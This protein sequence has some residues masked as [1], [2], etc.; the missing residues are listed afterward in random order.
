MRAI[1]KRLREKIK[2]LE[3]ENQAIKDDRQKFRE[4]MVQDLRKAIEHVRCN[5]YSSGNYIVEQVAKRMAS[6]KQWYWG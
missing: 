4:F 5:T 2:Q 6:V 1:E 3:I